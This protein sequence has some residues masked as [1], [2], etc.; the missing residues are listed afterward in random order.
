MKAL[1]LQ[2]F[3]SERRI[4]R[5]KEI[6][7]IYQKGKFLKGSLLHLWVLR[8]EA[9]PEKKAV[10]IA[11]SRKVS[12]KAVVRNRWRRLIREAFRKNQ[13]TLSN[14]SFLI[15]ARAVKRIPQYN[16]IE[17]ELQKLIRKSTES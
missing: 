17:S 3:S 12:L 13:Q 16:E 2:G 8:E 4:S 5:K 1:K 15:Q 10:V 14:G 9:K 11:V 7:F 6:D